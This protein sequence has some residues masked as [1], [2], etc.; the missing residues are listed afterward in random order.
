LITRGTA[1][2]GERELTEARQPTAAT[3]WRAN[4]TLA[5]TAMA[6]Y[7]IASMHAGSTG[8]MMEPV[9][10]EF[11]WSRTEFYFG[12]SLVS[13]VNMSL[14]TFTGVAIDRIGPRRVA[15]IAST[16]LFAAVAFMS[17]VGDDLFGWWARWLLVGI[18][19]SAMPTVWVAA[20]AARFEA[21]RGLAVAVA[22]SGSGI[23]TS[24]APII[25]HAL[26]ENY[27]WRAGYIGLSAIW[28][29]V[30]MPLILLFFHGPKRHAPATLAGQAVKQR[31][32][33]KDPEPRGV[34]LVMN[35]VP[36]LVST[37][38]ARGTAASVAGLIGIATI[39]GRITGGWLSDRMEAKFVA[40]AATIAAVVLPIGLLL[41]PGS[42]PIAAA[43]V[44]IYG[45]MGG[46]KVGAL[47]YLASRHLGQRAFGTL[48]G[49][50]N[51]T[52]A[53]AV[54][55]APLLANYV[56]DITQSYQPAMWAAVPI[57]VIAAL[58]YLMLGD[59]PDFAR[60]DERQPGR[61]TARK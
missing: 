6:G 30:A 42:V 46:A 13:F 10:R 51:A 39:V 56:Y 2:G 57:L 52:I 58:L 40:F 53:L 33:E 31:G 41:F 4:W 19:I 24:L 59:Y 36:V 25:T 35:L 7:S 5:L 17:T 60:G 28:A 37:G 9:T 16:L 8:V 3:E 43:S 11:G 20:V 61:A 54:A 21:S 27:G 47:A 44:V 15:I 48:Y 29:A 23:G 34:A 45:F 32:D 49:A 22:L 26:V 14:A 1:C 55:L 50:I 18:G 38:L 12:I